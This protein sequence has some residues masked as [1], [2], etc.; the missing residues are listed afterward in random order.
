MKWY[1]KLYVGDSA[2]RKKYEIVWKVKHNVGMINVYLITLSSNGHNL[3]DIFK[4]SMLKQKHFRKISSARK[5]IYVVGIACGYDEAV[6]VATKIVKEVYEKTNG[7]EIK[8]YLV[9][10][11]ERNNI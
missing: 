8:E 2:S 10:K 9:A 1:P 6:E 4:A 3:L 5:E 11:C 7:F